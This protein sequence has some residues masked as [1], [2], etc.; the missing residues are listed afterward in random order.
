MNQLN[1]Y[2]NQCSVWFSQSLVG[3]HAYAMSANQHADKNSNVF[4][5]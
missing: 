3:Y 1:S 5:S 4:H 2:T